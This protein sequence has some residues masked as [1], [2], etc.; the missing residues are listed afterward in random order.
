MESFMPFI[1]KRQGNEEIFTNDRYK[2]TSFQVP[3][4][5]KAFLPFGKWRPSLYL[6]PYVVLLLLPINGPDGS[7]SYRIYPPIGIIWGI[8]LGHT[9]GPG[10]LFFDLRYEMNLSMTIVQATGL[11][12]NQNRI[13]MSLGYRFGLWSRRNGQEAASKRT[14]GPSP[15][16]DPKPSPHTNEWMPNYPV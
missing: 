8:D 1:L 14:E 5:L 2:A 16:V 7:Y 4:L 15:A 10:E 3:V 9:L 13:S 12:Y 11:Q 6:G